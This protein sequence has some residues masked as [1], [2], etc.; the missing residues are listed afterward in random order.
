MVTVRKPPIKDLRIQELGHRITNMGD[1][2]LCNRCGQSWGL[3][4]RQNLIKTGLCM[5]GI[6]W[7]EPNGPNFPW[8]LQNDTQIVYLGRVLHQSHNIVFYRGVVYCLRCGY[9]TTGGRAHHLAT[10]CCV[11]SC[12]TKA[13]KAQEARLRRIRRGKCPRPGGW[14]A[15]EGEVTPTGLVPFVIKGTAC[16]IDSFEVAPRRGTETIWWPFTG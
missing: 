2:W 6:P 5:G 1:T 12:K 16:P 13:Y 4:A 9:Y 14:P 8:K 3:Q 15:P 10:Q 7:Q 11:K